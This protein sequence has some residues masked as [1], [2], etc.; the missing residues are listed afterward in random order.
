M[1]QL[2]PQLPGDS[3]S[4]QRAAISNRNG[5][6]V[7]FPGKTQVNCGGLTC[8]VAG[9]ATPEPFV[10]C[11]MRNPEMG[12]PVVN[13]Q[14]EVVLYLLSND[15]PPDGAPAARP[16]DFCV[17]VTGFSSDDCYASGSGVIPEGQWYTSVTVPAPPSGTVLYLFPSLDGMPMA[18]CGESPSI[19]FTIGGG[20]GGG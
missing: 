2:I 7:G 8:Q 6:V 11:L 5:L 4:I 10:F 15:T 18:P 3:E 14:D 16:F 13:E 1:A 20:G 12:D 19:Q 17:S 9:G